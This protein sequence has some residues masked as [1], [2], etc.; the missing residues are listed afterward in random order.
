MNAVYH[1]KYWLKHSSNPIATYSLRGLKYCLSR[2]LPVPITPYFLIA[3]LFKGVSTITTE[4]L[5]QLWWTPLFKTKLVTVPKRLYLYT[6]MPYISGPLSITVGEHCR[7]SGQTTF[8]GRYQENIAQS[9]PI[10][11]ELIIG[12][13]VGI[14]WQTTIAVGKKI[15]IGDNTRIAG[16]CFLAGYPGHPINPWDRAQGK[17]DTQNQVGDII[18]E[19]NVWLGTG[20]T[21]LAGVTIGRNTIIGTGS[22]VTK[23]LPQNVI[24]AGNPARVIR[25]LTLAELT[26]E[27]D[28]NVTA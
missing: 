24:A 26:Q 8:T 1:L 14:S 28:N 20:C 25:K 9:A 17:P 6:G 12:N 5:R 19:D 15:I 3:P 16:R 21:V 11:A 7:I 13:N 4:L 23:N 22:I 27:R 2:G 18:L 10:N